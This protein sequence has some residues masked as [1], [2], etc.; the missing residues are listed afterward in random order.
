MDVNQTAHAIVSAA[1][2]DE[3]A[4]DDFWN[5]LWAAGGDAEGMTLTPREVWWLTEELS[6]VYTMLDE[7]YAD[8]P[9]GAAQALGRRGGLKGGHARAAKMTPDERRESARKAAQARWSKRTEK[10]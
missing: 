10:A 9:R 4:E 7:G 1:T 5:R 3:R 6:R 8:G 2:D